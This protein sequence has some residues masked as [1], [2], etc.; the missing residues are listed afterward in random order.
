VQYLPPNYIS[1]D[2]VSGH[3]LIGKRHTARGHPENLDKRQETGKLET[4]RG[5]VHGARHMGKIRSRGAGEL[6]E[7]ATLRKIRRVQREGNCNVSRE[8]DYY[9]LDLKTSCF[10]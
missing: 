9:D 4:R 5:D 8:I 2:A 3:I 7:S 1:E 6:S 10:N